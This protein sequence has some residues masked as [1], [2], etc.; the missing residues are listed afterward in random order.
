MNTDIDHL[1]LVIGLPKSGKTTVMRR[2][3]HDHLRDYSSG[4]AI[5]HDTQ[6]QFRDLCASYETADDYRAAARLARSKGTP[7]PRG[8]AIT[9]VDSAQVTELAMELGRAHN[10]GRDI[11]P[12]PIYAA[13]DETSTMS[14]TQASWVD[15]R[16]WTMM[17]TRRH[18][19][20]SL[21]F[22]LQDVTNLP[23]KVFAM[24]TDVYI[25]RIPGPRAAR[26][27]EERL[28]LPPSYLDGLIAPPVGRCPQFVAAHWK[29][30]VGLV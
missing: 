13:F 12:L 25:M 6:M 9:G 27:L 30:G 17:V 7:L 26:M 23:P 14:A 4:I 15:G 20:I 19:C 16:D 29:Q 5:V 2:E 1:A 3:V 22:N 18:L 11:K 10:L 24:A 8:I 28:G 21:G